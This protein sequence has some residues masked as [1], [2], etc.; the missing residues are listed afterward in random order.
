[1]HII[2]LGDYMIGE[3]TLLKL[4][5]K[6]NINSN[7]IV[8]KNNN[9]LT[10]GEYIEIDRT[11]NYLVNELQIASYNI[12]KCPSILYRNVYAIKENINFLKEKDIH[13]ENIESC[14]HILSADPNS[15]RETY[16]YVKNNYGISALNRNTSILSCD[17]DIIISVENL[18]IKQEK[19]GNLTIAVGIEFGSTNI[20]EIKKII[21]S[22][23]Y[24]NHPEMFSPSVLAQ[25]KLEEIQ[26]I[27]KSEEFK[28]HPEM[29]NPSVLA[30]A[31]LEEIQKII[32]SE[33]FKEHPEIF[34]P[35]VLAR[36]KLENKK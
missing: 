23:E 5:E 11:L 6:Y 15:L 17:K 9:I 19:E 8:K 35:T 7:N 26:K 18:N 4:C 16:E 2:K 1:M 33:E 31:K 12:E 36:A 3:Y 25:A 29:F 27:I 24:K 14:L 21:Q 34:S 32:R 22:N 13:F 20:D 28:E 30:Y 10:K